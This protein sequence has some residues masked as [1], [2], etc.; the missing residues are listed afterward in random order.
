MS[1]PAATG[2]PCTALGVRLKRGAGAGCGRAVDVDERVALDV[3]RDGRAPASSR[4]PARSTPRGR[5]RTRPTP[6]SCGCGSASA[7]RAFSAGHCDR[8]IWRGRV[9]VVE[10]ERR[11]QRA[12]GSRRTSAR[13]TRSTR[14][15][16]RRSR[17]RCRSARRRRGCWCRAGPS[18]PIASRPTKM[19]ISCALP[20]TIAAS[21]T[22]PSPDVARSTSAARMPMHHERAAAAEVGE[23]V[24]RRDRRAA[25]G[26]DV[27]E[28]ARDR[29]VVDV[30]ADVAGRAGR[31]GPNP[32]MR[33]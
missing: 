6:R 21:T 24:D 26:A 25:F 28:H 32:V 8:S 15:R 27:P 9:E 14:T 29:E 5:R 7:M 16:R 17:T 19:L 4:G 2:A 11:E 30:V 23:Q 22:W 12:A 10:A 18:V 33:A 13:T 20:S 3:V 1:A 31:P